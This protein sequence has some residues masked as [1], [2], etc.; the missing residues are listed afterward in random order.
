MSREIALNIQGAE[1]LAA[2]MQRLIDLA[3]EVLDKAMMK[4]AKGFTEDCNTLMPSK[5]SFRKTWERKKIT[6]EF[7]ITSEIQ[8]R[9][10]APHW[11]LIENGHRKWLY[12]VDTGGFVPGRHYA[13]RTREVY[14]DRYPE[15]IGA[16]VHA[17]MQKAGL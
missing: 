15:I 16:A 1:E 10:R 13:E 2:E 11:H 4:A 14:R 8:V 7:G 3:P 9:N 6:G 12:G 5:Y 17:A